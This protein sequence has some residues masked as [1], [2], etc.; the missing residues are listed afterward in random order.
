MKIENILKDAGIRATS[1]RMEVLN[2]LYSIDCPVS[3]KEILENPGIKGFNRVTVYRTLNKL[4]EVRLVYKV[5]GRGGFWRFCAHV[6]GQKGY[7]G[8]HPHFLCLKCGSMKCF[9]DQVLPWI[10]VP[11][12]VEVKGKQM[13]I[14]GICKKCPTGKKK[15]I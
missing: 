8:N 12:G 7:P 4:V 6:P 13:L 3:H 14:Y 10:Q 11:Q 15:E 2:L 5:L 9:T 1:I